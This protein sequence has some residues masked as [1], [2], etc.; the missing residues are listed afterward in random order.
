MARKDWDY[1]HI[2]KEM[3][4]AFDHIV[5][6]EGKKYGIMD[7]KEFVRYVLRRALIV[8]EKE[9]GIIPLDSIRLEA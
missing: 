1:I 5:E 8:Y 2:P 9:H 4:G 7:R 3:A 6:K